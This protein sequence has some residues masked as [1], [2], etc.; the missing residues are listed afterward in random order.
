[1][2]EDVDLIDERQDIRKKSE[3]LAKRSEEIDRKLSG[4]Q[5]TLQ[6]FHLYS[7]AQEVPTELTRKIQTTLSETLAEIGKRMSLF[8]VITSTGEVPKTLT[9]CCRDILRRSGQWLA[10]IDVRDALLATGFDFSKY[11][12]N[13]LT[14]IH[15]TLKRL[16]E[17]GEVEDKAD[18]EGPTFYRWKNQ[19]P[20]RQTTAPPPITTLSGR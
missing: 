3:E 14:S 6:G 5:Q 4:I 10:A 8:D 16:K 18:E 19:Q 9:E 2:L 1:M 7:K 17:S 13:P 20:K 11:T 15:T 12:S